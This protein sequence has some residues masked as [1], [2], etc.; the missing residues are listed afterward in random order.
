VRKGSQP[1]SWSSIMISP[2]PKELEAAVTVM[3]NDI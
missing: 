2:K 3:S 1:L